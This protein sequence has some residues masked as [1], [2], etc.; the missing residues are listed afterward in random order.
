MTDHH[1]SSAANIGEDKDSVPHQRKAIQAHA[2]KAGNTIV[3][4]FDDPAVTGD[5]IDMRPGFE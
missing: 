5:M 3:A 4:R 1:P 2:N